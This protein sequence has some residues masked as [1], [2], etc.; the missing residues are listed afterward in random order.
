MF[1]FDFIYLQQDCQWRLVHLMLVVEGRR[2]LP[3]IVSVLSVVE[4]RRPLPDI[5]SVLSRNRCE[6]SSAKKHL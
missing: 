1:D 2:P 3:D 5:V 4:G 6:T